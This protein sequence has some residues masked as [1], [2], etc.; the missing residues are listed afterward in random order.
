MFFGLI[1]GKREE[2]TKKFSV[3]IHTRMPSD[4]PGSL[5]RTFFVEN[6]SAVLDESTRAFTL[7]AGEQIEKIV[8]VELK[9]K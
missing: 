4:M 2:K 6:L 5:D 9:G 7:I 3:R 8:I 1:G